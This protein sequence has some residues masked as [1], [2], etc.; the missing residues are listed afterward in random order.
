MN[1]AVRSGRTQPSSGINDPTAM[2][3]NK[4]R[5]WKTQAT[6]DTGGATQRGQEPAVV[7]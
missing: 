5:A 1:L 2:L 3:V 4:S 7:A 6:L